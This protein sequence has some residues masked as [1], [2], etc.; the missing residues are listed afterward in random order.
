MATFDFISGEDFRFSLEKD[1]QELNSAMQVGAW[2]AV[3]VLAGSI[4]EAILVDYLVASGYQKKNPLNMSLSEAITACKEEKIL[5]EKTEQISHAIRSYRNLIHPGRLIRLGEIANENGA[6]IAQALV[7][8]VVGEVA[9][10]RREKYGYTAE[11]IVRKIESDPSTTAIL[12]YLLKS[13]NEF[14]KERLLLNV[15][16]QEYFHLAA[17]DEEATAKALSSLTL[18]FRIVFENAS[19]ETKRKVAKNF[20]KVL[21]EESQTVVQAHQ[22][23]FFKG[24]DLAYL[25]PEE[26]QLVKHYLFSVL[27]KDVTSTLLKAMEGIGENLIIED[28]SNLM[29]PIII[30][31]TDFNDEHISISQAKTFLDAEYPKMNK[32]VKELVLERL[33]KNNWIINNEIFIEEMEKIRDHLISLDQI[34][35]IDWDDLPDWDDLL[36]H[37]PNQ[38]KEEELPPNW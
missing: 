19:E 37:V 25:S 26:A 30:S 6:R 4:I 28:V 12:E 9:E 22:K 10:T 34:K 2:K 20:V 11:Q 16:P 24:K 23:W 7:E 8:V 29:N 21:K 38:S 32:E 14:E 5:S 17:L 18:C 35:H 13:T 33:D 15:I 27:K 31:M 36:T 1:Y 3:H